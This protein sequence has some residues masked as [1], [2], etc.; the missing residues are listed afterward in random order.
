MPCPTAGNVSMIRRPPASTN[1]TAAAAMS[2][3]A[4]PGRIIPMISHMTCWLTA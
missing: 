3:R 1:S 2:L 4:T